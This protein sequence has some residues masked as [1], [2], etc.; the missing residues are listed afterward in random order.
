MIYF[1]VSSRN[2]CPRWA[3]WS[4]AREALRLGSPL[5]ACA[6]A[7]EMDRL[8]VACAFPRGCRK[9]AARTTAPRWREVSVLERPGAEWSQEQG[10]VR[11]V[12]DYPRSRGPDSSGTWRSRSFTELRL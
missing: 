5:R 7:V 1:K 12:G 4:G 9:R 3:P 10:V 11:G 6:L 2:T 8:A